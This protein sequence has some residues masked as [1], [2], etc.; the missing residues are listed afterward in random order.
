VDEVL[1]CLTVEGSVGVIVPDARTEWTLR[2][3]RSAGID[4]H[5]VDDDADPRVEVVPAS[6]AKG[7]EFDSVVLLEPA[8]IVAAEP[9]RV[10]GLRRLYVVLTRAVSRLRIVHDRPLPPELE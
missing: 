5:V 7:L 2:M 3:L 10:D 4:A 1:D 6:Q 9:S 8:E